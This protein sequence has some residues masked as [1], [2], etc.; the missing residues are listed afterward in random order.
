MRISTNQIYDQN[1]RAIMDNQRGLTDTQESLATGKKLN[2]PSDD[3]VGAAKVIRLTEELD[4]LNQYQ[5]NIDLVTGSLEQQE[6]VLSNINDAANRART[7]AIQAGSGILSDSDRRAIGAEM[8][9][10]RDEVFDLMNSQDA[11]GN[12]I[13]AG[14]QSQNQA[15]TLNPAATTN[16]VTFAGDAGENSVQLSDSTQVQSTTSGQ[17]VFQNVL[18]RRDFA[19]SGTPTASVQESLITEQGTFDT[20]HK[21]SYDPVTAANNNF[22]LT[23][24]AG[25]QAQL[26]NINSGAVVDTVSYASGEPFTVKGMQ[27]TLSGSVGDTVDITLDPPAKKNLANTIDDL[28]RVLSNSTSGVD[29]REAISDAVVGID[30]AQEKIAL[31]RSSIGGRLNVAE[32]IYETNLDLEIAAKETRS[33]IEDVDYAEASAEFAK[34]ET[35]LNAA[36]ATFPRISNLSLFDY[37]S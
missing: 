20:F 32:S 17:E 8:E 18:A 22:R 14:H 21:N 16:P 3:P 13:F 15:F 6:A 2:R 33:S 34:Q 30:N 11:D 26:T 27:F 28:Y 10:L 31:E 29:L 23:L 25:N 4:Q 37:I 12:Y 7:L 35:A 24:Q 19:I 1:I 5:R 36:L 9:Q